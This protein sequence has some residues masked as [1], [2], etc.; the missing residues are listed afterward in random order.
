MMDTDPLDMTEKEKKILDGPY[1]RT[2]FIRSEK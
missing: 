1:C 2:M